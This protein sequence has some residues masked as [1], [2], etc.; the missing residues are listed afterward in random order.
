MVSAPRSEDSTGVT[1]E[2]SWLSDDSLADSPDAQE[3]E[4][5]DWVRS[6]EDMLNDT[7]DD[8]PDWMQSADTSDDNYESDEPLEPKHGLLGRFGDDDD[9][10]LPDE[11]DPTTS[12]DQS[13]NW[14]IN[15]GETGALSEEHHDDHPSWLGDTG[16]FSQEQIQ[17][18]L[19]AIES[20]EDEAASTADEVPDWLSGGM[21][22]DDDGSNDEEDDVASLPDEVPDWLS[23]AM[24][25]NDDADESEA[26]LEMPDMDTMFGF[27]DDEYDDQDDALD[28]P[29]M[30]TMFGF[31]DEPVA[32]PAADGNSTDWMN[33]YDGDDDEF[34]SDSPQSASA[35]DSEDDDEE[36]ADTGWLE[37]DDDGEAEV[38]D[39]YAQYGDNTED[40]EEEYEDIFAT[41]G[42]VDTGMLTS[43]ADL[44]SDD[45][46]VSAPIAHDETPDWLSGFGDDDEFGAE[47][48]TA[49][50]APATQGD[51]AWLE[52][53]GD[54][55]S[56][57]DPLDDVPD[58][59]KGDASDESIPTADPSE[60]ADAPEIT[61]DDL[62]ADLGMADETISRVPTGLT[63]ELADFDS[64]DEFELDLFG[65]VDEDISRASTGLTGELSQLDDADFDFLDEDDEDISPVS[66]GLTGELSQLDDADFDFLGDIDEDISRASTGL[67]GELSQLDDSD[68][69]FL[70]EIDMDDLDFDDLDLDD[71]P[72][73]GLTGELA[74]LDDEM[75]LSFLDEVDDDLDRMPT[76]ATGD[77]Q[78]LD[79]EMDLSFLDEVED[80][81]AEDWFAEPDE[82]EE[83]DPD[84][85]QTL[86]DTSDADF[87]DE[88]D[89]FDFAEMLDGIEID[90]SVFDSEEMDAPAADLNSLLSTFDDVE[91]SDFAEA[92]DLSQIED[93]DAIF[94][95][96]LSQ[97][98]IDLDD[99]M[100]ENIP[101]WLRGV[102]I[103]SDESSAAAIIRQQADRPIDDLDDR[104]QALREKGLSVSSQASDDLANASAPDV[105]SGVS[106]TLGTPQIAHEIGVLISDV[107]LTGD[108]QKQ[109][110]L[111]QK[112]VGVT[113]TPTVETDAD[114]IPIVESSRRSRRFLP[115]IGI[116]RLL[117]A[118]I[119]VLTLILPFVSNFGVGSLPPVAFGA[120][121]RSANAVF[122]QIES[123]NEGDWVL[124]GFEYGPTAAGEL[125]SVS[126]IL[127]RHI[128]SRGAKPI[129][130]SSNPVAIVHAQN[131]VKDINQAVTPSGISLVANQDYYFVRYLTGGTLG[132]RDL[133]LNLDSIVSI[134]VKG[135]ATN[136]HV[137]SLDEMALMVL[138]AESSEDIRTWSEQITP[139]TS[140]RLVAATGYA[141]Q[142][143]AEPY[144]NQTE[145]IIGLVVGYRDAYTYAEMLQGLFATPTPV[146][147]ETFTATFTETDIPADTDTPVPTV[148]PIPTETVDSSSAD[149]TAQGAGA[150][151]VTP[152][153]GDTS[154]EGDATALPSNTAVPTVTPVPSNT[155]LP[156]ASVTIAATV[157]PLPTNTLSPSNT[158]VP[159]ATANLITVIV[160]TAPD[161]SVN[162]RTGPGT[163]FN[164]VTTVNSG[165]VFQ[166]IEENEDGSWIHFLLPDGR[167]G[168]IAS[169]LVEKTE[170]P[171]ADLESDD[172]ASAGRD[173]TVMQLSFNRRL[174]KNRVRYS[175][176][177]STE[178]ATAT[179]T[180]T[181]PTA[182][183][184]FTPS[185]TFTPSM[186]PTATLTPTATPDPSA[187]FAFARD[188][189]QEESRL[190]AMTLGTIAAVVIILLGNIF[191]GLR[192]MAQRRRESKR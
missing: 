17:R 149:A 108:Q 16:T 128:F 172:S 10:N 144:V 85:M 101:E 29:N 131:V 165:E 127:L 146:P 152:V 55:E 44:F 71:I 159:T 60:F 139:S 74:E 12:S 102:D 135:Q 47:E 95:A 64:D 176:Q 155:A 81:D 77:L 179:V 189:K 120:D 140:T 180:G 167:D 18:H 73:T 153:T 183:P 98:D 192:A 123:L 35:D 169:F 63:G 111:L 28:M 87:A 114:G 122:N 191:Y 177:Q 116:G 58:W 150:D 38:Y 53:F 151:D 14:L 156:T 130:V 90:D 93:L 145:G 115:N 34:S 134:D 41:D 7:S 8:T 175:Q 80:N 119:L 21:F 186:T 164:V 42:I 100:P 56:F 26:P 9:V 121:N 32:E 113:I 178:T 190:E 36:P 61:A 5:G 161:G 94:D 2:L 84:W 48:E 187:P 15:M 160:V 174:G 54:D 33:Q 166:V 3:S 129:I 125:D 23:G 27:D 133:I 142:P 147:T 106:E 65:E 66:T 69:D 117:V 86:A 181:P 83:G 30:D 37:F 78:A 82:H 43:Q 112:I 168:W 103:S 173:V 67:T 110:K 39:P 75:D 79:D 154:G 76:G 11:V 89:D 45:E 182:T 51:M 107:T 59:L 138:I 157:T 124:V 1:G 70:G 52:D 88:S 49:D 40:E 104:L 105:L 148:T 143:L 158:P 19:D 22:G 132:L 118:S 24:F 126:D 184:T 109:S 137:S 4:D 99:D 163:T 91:D 92:E 96:A 141:A 57:G 185:A 6:D 62:L 13:P 188:R 25:A 97:D 162:V 136:L 31:D 170:L 68:F 72:S 171:E 50:E 46:P 20:E